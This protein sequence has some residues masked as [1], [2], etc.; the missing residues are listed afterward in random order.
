MAPEVISSKDGYSFEVDIWSL[1]VTAFLLLSG[2][3]P[4]EKQDTLSVFSEIKN[5]D[6][7]YRTNLSTLGQSLVSKML[8]INPNDRWRVKQL[9]KH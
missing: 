9:L 8:V 3:F 4:F 1:G 5:R 2:R 6:I 7:F